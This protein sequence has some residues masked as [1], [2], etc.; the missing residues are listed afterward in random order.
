MMNWNWWHAAAATLGLCVAAAAF[1]SAPLPL[2][3]VISA[4]DLI[5]EAAATGATIEPYLAS[6]EAYMQNVDK[7]KP[8]ASLL[9]VIGQALAE[10]PQETKLKS[11]GPSLR[12]ASILIARSKTYEEAKAAWPQVQAALQGQATGQPAVE[13]DWA[14]LSKMHPAMEEMNARGTALRRLLRR[15]KDPAA[16]SRNAAVIA[17][18]AVTAHADTHEVKNPVDT[19]KWH[20]FAT[21]LQQHM[22]AAAA[23]IKAKDA[24]AGTKHFQAGMETCNKCHE[25]FHKE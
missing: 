5:A 9:A 14:K 18:L 8:S 3:K 19:P 25:V 2:D 24:A 20:E 7:L 11:A 16:D 1:A 22:S 15:P 4:E 21:A 6:A 23:A 13:F 10:H 17:L 12:E